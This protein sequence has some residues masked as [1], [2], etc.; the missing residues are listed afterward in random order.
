MP[1]PRFVRL[2]P[3]EDASLRKAEQDPYLK[4]KVRLRAQVLRLTS[5]GEKLKQAILHALRLLG[6]VELQCQRGD[7]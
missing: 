4:P 2:K 6:A 5:R 3:E 1:A 7:T